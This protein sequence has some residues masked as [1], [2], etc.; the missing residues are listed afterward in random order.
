MDRNKA[1]SQFSRQVK[2]TNDYYYY[3]YYFKPQVQS[4]ML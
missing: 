2:R 3:Y 4:R 1:Y